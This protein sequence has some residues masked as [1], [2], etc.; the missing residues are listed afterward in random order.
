MVIELALAFFGRGSVDFFMLE[1]F[2]TPPFCFI[3]EDPSRDN[4]DPGRDKARSTESPE[5]KKHNE[6]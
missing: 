5:T 6:N 2:S 3:M 1:D 4:G